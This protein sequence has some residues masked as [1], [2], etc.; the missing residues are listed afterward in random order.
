MTSSEFTTIVNEK[1]TEL[2]MKQLYY[3]NMYKQEKETRRIKMDHTNLRDEEEQALIINISIFPL[4]VIPP[5][6]TVQPRYNKSDEEL[7]ACCWY[8]ILKFER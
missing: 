5:T 1:T 4:F 6:R 8:F 2:R 7:A 3:F